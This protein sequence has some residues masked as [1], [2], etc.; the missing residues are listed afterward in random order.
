MTHSIGLNDYREIQLEQGVIRY[1]DEGDGPTLLFVHGIFVNSALWRDVVSHLSGQFR[2]VAPDL[3]LGGHSVPMGSNADLTPIGVAKIVADF[4]EALDLHDVTLI[5]NDT[6]GAICQIVVAGHSE[7][8]ARLVLTNCDAYDAFFPLL[9]RPFHYGA[10]F[11]GK[12]FSTVIARALTFRFAQRSFAWAVSRRRQQEEI[13]DA[14]FTPFL[15]EEGVRR[16]AAKFLAAVSNRHTLEAAS[17]FSSFT[18][19]VLIVW[20]NDDFIF[21]PRLARRLQHDFPDAR[22]EFIEDSR[23][24][25]PEDQPKALVARIR[26][27]VA[28]PNI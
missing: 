19:P 9:L 5:G 6:G 22:L 20:G 23:A 26:E 21:R 24:F 7:R 16:D 15:K 8:L 14:Y 4:M 28:E 27:F 3:P 1:R 13:L 11:F 17:H 10:R 25:I 18:K 2:C 12:R